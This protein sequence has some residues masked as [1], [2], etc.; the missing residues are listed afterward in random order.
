[1]AAGR[2]GSRKAILRALYAIVSTAFAAPEV[3][4]PFN[5]QVPT[6]ARVGQEYAFQLS[7]STFAPQSTNFTYS[8]S[9][10]PAWL[11]VDSVTRTLMGA[12]SQADVGASTFTLVAADSN[13]AAYMDCTLVVSTDPPPQLEVDI[14]Q[15]L[16]ATANL[17]STQPPVVTLLPLSPFNFD[18]R[19]GSFIDIVQR[20][21]YYY[22]TLT[23][24]TPLPSWLI[25]DSQRL[26][27]SGM[28]PELTAFP[29]SWD[30]NLIASDVEGFA[31]STA[32]YTLAVGT[33][34]LVFVPEQQ[35][36]D[37]TLGMHIQ[38]TG[39][40]DDLFLN[41]K[42]VEPLALKSASASVPSWL[43]F[44]SSTLEMTG[45]V[46]N[47]VKGQNIT[48][49][50]EDK[51][52]NQATA[53]V[54]FLVTNSSLFTETIGTLTAHSGQMFSYRFADA[55]FT[56]EHVELM[57]TLPATA[58]WLKFDAD[59]R[60]LHGQ[61]PTQTTP[62]TVEATLR[63]RSPNI[64]EGETQQFAINVLASATTASAPVD[65]T[66]HHS[67]S[68]TLAVG[69]NTSK[70]EEP[71]SHLTRG[72]MAA[73]VIGALI[74]IA[75]LAACLILCW[76]RRKR[77]EG[78]VEATS[79]AKR[80][81][82]KPILP[83]DSDTIR[84]TTEVQTDIEKAAEG[85]TQQD[86]AAESECAPQIALNLPMRTNS[87][88]SK[89]TKR[90]SRTS[91]ASSLGNGEGAIRADSNIPELGRQSAALHAPHDSFSVP[92]E[93]ARSSRQLPELSPGK[94]A[95]RF[96]REKRQSGQSIG[97]G[98]HT[99]GAGLLPQHSYRGARSHRR[100][101][102]SLG[103]SAAMDRSSIASL[104]TRGTSLLSTRASEF[105]RP[106]TRSTFTGSK[107]IPTLSLTEGENKKSIRLV[108]PSDS[109]P[110]NRSLQD[111]RQSFIRNRASTS[112][113]SPL[114]AHGSR[115][116]SNTQQNGRTSANAS[117]T[118]SRRRSKRG[119]SNLTTYSES[120][121]VE[122]PPKDPRRFSA[123]LRSTFAPSFPRAIAKST[124]AG[125]D[126]DAENGDSNSDFYTTS[127]SISGA[128]L[129]AEMALPRD[130]RPWALPGETPTPP[131]ANQ[132]CSLRSNDW[133]SRSE[134]RR[135]LWKERLREHSSSPLST[136]VAVAVPVTDRSPLSADAKA[137]QARRSRLSEPISLVSN[138]SLS[139]TNKLERPRLVQTNSKR[140]VSVEKCQ[141]LS[142]LKA[143]TEDARPG[144]E[145]WEAMEG[146]GLLSP[147]RGDGEDGTQK[148]N[149]GGPAFI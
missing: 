31:G 101:V 149:M 62:T 95:L 7:S 33:Q 4:F 9:D 108:D 30:I 53:L 102:S 100:A 91:L 83:P 119:R 142:S 39:L 103:L 10:Q 72:I 125:E 6:V 8:L 105:P 25:F 122:P 41:G 97:L 71:H 63:V 45:I 106:P 61:V 96:L 74:G 48:V 88:R 34:Q 13:G 40:K 146:A 86:R 27:F 117:S 22:A 73:V 140:P 98:I 14:N 68:E 57:V 120:S 133:A 44:D 134:R 76:R 50:V 18:F 94:R 56:E 49:T 148:S 104:S 109:A 93:M 89:W 16:A 114:F 67:T 131:P 78:Y 79:P 80:T 55:L 1:M 42:R 59:T 130:Q 123:R 136:A 87:K 126:Y 92:A 2:L 60:E 36:V 81:I 116:S 127:S 38:Y 11:S 20:K 145:M 112:F 19:Q 46:P 111:K 28:A 17:S 51:S 135:Q 85:G 128:D 12:P 70:K 138:D 115:V 82:S 99:N 21:L 137:S 3:A 52:G 75:L 147:S 65:V 124:L 107:S 69:S 26:V 29:Q 58:T 118:S 121:S 47:G 54:R 43:I 143:E 139:R 24:H 132:A 113:A 15:Q 64:P 35:R 129:A 23:D 110:D 5:S 32:S 90:F 77:H 144:S 84:V 66:S 37:I 141:R